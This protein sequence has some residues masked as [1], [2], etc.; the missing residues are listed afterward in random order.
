MQFA[1]G[2]GIVL[3]LGVIATPIITRIINPEEMGK[4]SMFNTVANLL[5][6]VVCLGID[7]AYIR[8]YYDEDE[9][10]RGK[11]L[12]KC[13]KIPMAINMV[14]TVF[15]LILYKPL[16]MYMVAEESIIIIVLLVIHITGSIISRFS[17]LQVRMRQR[18]KFYSFLNI[19]MKMSYLILVSIFFT[20]LNNNYI[21]LVLATIFS[22]ILMAIVGIVVERKEWFNFNKMDHLKTST[23]EIV[24]YGIPFI[25]SMAITWLFQSIDRIAIKE[26][27][28]YSQVGLYSGAMNIIS[29]LNAC[30][31]AFTTFWIPV[32]YEKYCNNP[33]NTQFFARINEIVSVG[34]LLVSIILIFGKDVMILLLGQE[35]REAMF[36]FPYLVFMPIM[37]TISETTVIGIN[38][39]KKTKNHIYIAI[40]SAITNIIGNLILVPKLGAKGAAISTGIS[41][42]IFFLART[43]FSSKYYKVKYKLI[44]FYLAT[45]MTYILATYASFNTF[46][47]QIIILTIISIGVVIIMYRKLIIEIF[48]KIRKFIRVNYL[49]IWR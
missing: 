21:I 28:G 42:I 6:L 30:Q 31:G 46:N 45:F 35:Y 4:F 34:M 38:F 41:Y 20:V 43:Y 7:Q 10:N 36:I 48:I 33:E 29:L 19:L 5:L 27:C 9:S 47:I 14:L 44:K 37:Y 18:A 11:L 13:I 16:S 49:Y 25:F 23:K 24:M 26:F 17:L 12:D 1:M 40:I 22:N 8:F 32:A 2:N 15:I 39:K 3:F